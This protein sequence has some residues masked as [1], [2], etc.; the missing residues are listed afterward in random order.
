MARR[1]LK[2]PINYQIQLDEFQKEAKESII[3]NQITVITGKAGSGKTSCAVQAAID[4]FFKKEV[5]KILITR[6]IVEV[7][8]SLGFLPGELTTKYNP[9]IE[10]VLDS[11]YACYG[12]KE[13]VK[14]HIE[15]GDV[16]GYPIAYVRGKNM[17]DFLLV[18][19]VQNLSELEVKALCS[20]LTPTGRIVFVG[21][22]DQNDT[23]R[24]YT[25]LHYLIDMCKAL[26]Q[27]KMHKLKNNHRSSIV[28]DILEWDYNRKKTNEQ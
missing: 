26:P 5:S 24:S 6:P 3:N 9:Y 16:Q 21:D 17:S 20:R 7:G 22:I 25:G 23:K 10:P 28:G 12:D 11:L 27:I 8:S 1:D 4:M 18:D 2:N 15:S 19:E 14:K 13:K